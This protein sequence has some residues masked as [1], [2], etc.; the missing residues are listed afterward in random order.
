M[1]GAS[2]MAVQVVALMMVMVIMRIRIGMGISVQRQ[3]GGS[4]PSGVGRTRVAEQHRVEHNT[5]RRCGSA[6]DRLHVS[7]TAQTEVC[8]ALQA[9]TCSNCVGSNT[10]DTH[11]DRPA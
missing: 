5:R 11:S 10:D 3:G 2:A 4:E 9:G 6:H 8:D 1:A 7:E